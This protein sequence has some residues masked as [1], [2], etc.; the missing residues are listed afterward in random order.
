MVVGGV[1]SAWRSHKYW[2]S[3]VPVFFGTCHSALAFWIAIR[4]WNGQT[5]D[6]L[7]TCL[8][9]DLCFLRYKWLKPLPVLVEIQCLSWV[10]ALSWRLCV[11][12]LFRLLDLLLFS[13][14]RMQLCNLS[15]FCNPSG[16][17]VYTRIIMHWISDMTCRHSWQVLEGPLPS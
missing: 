14:L 16:R 15:C 7:D 8:S 2:V 11:P 9:S 13:T 5:F 17:L 3:L 4:G 12:R 10:S 6:K 1:R